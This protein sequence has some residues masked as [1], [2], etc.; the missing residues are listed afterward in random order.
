MEYVAIG[1]LALFVPRWAVAT[2]LSLAVLLDLLDGVCQTYF[3]VASQCLTS[4]SAVGNLLLPGFL[5]E[6]LSVS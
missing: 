4:L 2:L 1:V 3:M 5:Q 6:S